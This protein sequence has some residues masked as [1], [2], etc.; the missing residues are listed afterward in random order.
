[1]KILGSDFDGTLTH[2]LGE[3]TYK[4]IRAWR[5]A[6]NKFGIVSGRGTGFPETIRARY[7]DL[8]LDFF[9]GFNGGAIANGNREIIFE[10]RYAEVASEKL[11]EDLLDWGCPF[12][13]YN[14]DQHFCVIRRDEDKPA[15]EDAKV[16]VKPDGLPPLPYFVQISTQFP[17]DESRAAEVV[18]LIRKAYGIRLNPLQ[19]GTCIDIVPPDINKAEGLSRIAAHYGARREDLIAVGDNINDTDMIAAFRSYAMESGVESIKR[20]ATKTVETVA[21]LIWRELGERE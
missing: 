1:M 6:G 20:L 2:K 8:E 4:A 18:E 15:W 3:E 16:I 5:A 10:R 7:P 17:G 14:G 13:F 12:V 9:V 19:N 21:E 11:I